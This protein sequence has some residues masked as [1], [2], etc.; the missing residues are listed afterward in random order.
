MARADRVLV[1]SLDYAEHSA[2]GKLGL[3]SQIEELP[4]GIDLTRFHP[5]SE[6][7]VREGMGIGPEQ[8]LALFVGGMD[9][10]HAFKGVPVLLEALAHLPD[11][12]L[13]VALV[14]DGDLRPVFEQTAIHL[15]LSSR[16]RF[17][18]NVADGELPALYRA[19]DLHVLPST[20][21]GEAFGMVALEAAASGIPS[22]VSDLPG[23]RTVVLDGETG[24]RVKPGDPDALAAAL[25]RLV[26]EPGPRRALGAAARARA[27]HAFAWGPLM[28]RLEFVYRTLSQSLASRTDS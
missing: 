6:P 16:V 17:L 15:G 26:Q 18:G 9:T 20:T 14:G 19:A 27:E 4:F 7:S 13:T 3:G 12:P 21:R 11:V 10:P 8:A 1:S 23:V 24:L 28:D 22:V 2:L 25:R 5:G